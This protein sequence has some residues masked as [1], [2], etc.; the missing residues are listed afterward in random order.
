M[1]QI[2]NKFIIMLS[3]IGQFYIYLNFSCRND[4]EKLID[5]RNNVEMGAPL[6][7]SDSFKKQ[8]K[9]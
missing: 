8:S 3:N 7:T 5:P 1:E 6:E 4:A 2:T 9:F